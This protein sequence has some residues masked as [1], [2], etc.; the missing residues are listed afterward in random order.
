[1]FRDRTLACTLI[2]NKAI[3]ILFW[4]LSFRTFLYECYLLIFRIS[5]VTG[6]FPDSVLVPQNQ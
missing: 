3:E 1:M 5:H 4:L 2:K 6:L